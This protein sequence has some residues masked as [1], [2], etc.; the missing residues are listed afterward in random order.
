MSGGVKICQTDTPAARATTSSIF[1]DKLRNAIIEPN[2]TA[3]GRACSANRR[4]PQERQQGHE[5][6]RRPLRIARAAHQFDEIDRVDK[7]E[8]QQKRRNDRAREAF[9]EIDRERSADHAG[10]LT[11][12]RRARSH[13]APQNQ[14]QRPQAGGNRD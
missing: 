14:R 5:N 12:R 1:R 4:G 10:L 6:A 2:R 3:N 13:Q 11:A 9:G 8:D 7:D